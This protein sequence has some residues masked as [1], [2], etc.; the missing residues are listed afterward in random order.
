MPH[1]SKRRLEKQHIQDL[2]LEIVFVFERASRRG[3]LRHVLGQLLTSTEKIMLAKRLAV[4]AML[5]QGIP[6]HNIAE[7]LSMSPSTIDI[8]SLKF[9]TENY[10]HIVKS[11]LKR[12]DVGDVIRMIQTVGGI[13]PPRSGQGRWKY[14]DDSF[15]RDRIASR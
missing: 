13:M 6:I 14:L 8:M 5:S 9:E 2:F 11:G 3:E 1:I 15:R 4:V 7:G 10:S 12:T